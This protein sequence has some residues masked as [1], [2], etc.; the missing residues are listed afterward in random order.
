MDLRRGGGIEE[1]DAG[2]A[3]GLEQ[4]ARLLTAEVFARWQPRAGKPRDTNL[5]E[6]LLIK[7]KYI[8]GKITD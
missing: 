3:L 6:R 5:S 2:S 1:G 4:A 8:K 7:C